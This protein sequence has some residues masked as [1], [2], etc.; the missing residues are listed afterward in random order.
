MLPQRFEEESI[1]TRETQAIQDDIAYMRSLAHPQ[2]RKIRNSRRFCLRL[3]RNE[4]R[5]LH[6]NDPRFLRLMSSLAAKTRQRI[7]LFRQNE[8]RLPWGVVMYVYLTGCR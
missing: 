7:F 8:I 5:S 1:M 6:R 2:L 4:C 3:R